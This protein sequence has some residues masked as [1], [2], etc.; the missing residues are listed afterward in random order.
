MQSVMAEWRAIGDSRFTAFGLHTLGQSALILGRYAE[1]RAALEESVALNVYAGARWNLGF[2]YQGLG[3]VVQA[4]GE[5]EQAVVM[6]RKSLDTFTELGGRQFVAQGL[7]EMGRSLFAMGNDMEAERVWCESLCIAT[8]THGTPVALEALVGLANL[9][10]KL[11]DIELAF[12]LLLIVLDHPAVLQETRNRAVQLHSE[13]E[14]QLTRHQV[15]AARG[16]SQAKTFEAVVDE[17]LK[18]V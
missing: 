15:E 5:H 18:K 14:A 1:A 9:H 2:A 8:E 16:R 10:G 6:Y 4:Q 11:G 12:E 7:A 17:I 13:L 3:D